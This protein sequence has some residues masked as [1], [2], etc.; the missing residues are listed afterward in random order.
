MLKNNFNIRD[1][2]ELDRAMNRYASAAWAYMEGA[3]PLHP[4]FMYLRRIH[5]MM[6]GRLFPWAGTVRDVDATAVGT[7]IVYARPTFIQT[8][9]DDLFS[10]LE[11]ED[12]LSGIP[13]V[14]EFSQALASRWADLTQL[15]PFRDG[16]TRSQSLFVSTLARRAEHPLAWDRIDVNELHR[17][18]LRAV[19]G[20][21]QGLSNYLRNAIIPAEYSRTGGIDCEFPMPRA[22]VPCALPVGHG[23]HH[24]SKKRGKR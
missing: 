5:S 8:G 20:D 12:Y 13:D 22:K 6:F 17:H 24:L 14:D 23:G 3:V 21:E 9:I 19:S 4:D 18:R 2:R 15:H 11:G 10:K 16:N 1:A 7:G